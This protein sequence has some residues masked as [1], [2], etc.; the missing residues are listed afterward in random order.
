[1]GSPAGRPLWV[2][3][4]LR[5]IFPRH[6]LQLW[7]AVQSCFSMHFMVSHPHVKVKSLTLACSNGT[8]GFQGTVTIFAIVLNPPILFTGV[9]K[10]CFLQLAERD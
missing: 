1:M 5:T 9:F 3:H 7:P 2:P 4:C 8:I 10:L 6:T